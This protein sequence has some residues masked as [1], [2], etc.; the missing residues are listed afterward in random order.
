M[1]TSNATELNQVPVSW[2]VVG[3]TILAVMQFVKF[4][5]SKGRDLPLFGGAA[6]FCVVATFSAASNPSAILCARGR[7]ERWEVVLDLNLRSI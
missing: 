4:A 1:R 5:W 3:C 2:L 6:T 7:L